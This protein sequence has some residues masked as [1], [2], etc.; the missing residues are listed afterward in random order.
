MPRPGLAGAERA[1]KVGAR[2][3]AAGEKSIAF[4]FLSLT[5]LAGQTDVL[6]VVAIDAL[7]CLSV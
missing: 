7:R 5:G 4:D 1:L 2:T 3:L 6:V